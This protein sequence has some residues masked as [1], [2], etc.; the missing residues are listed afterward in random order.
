ML[1]LPSVGG[2]AHDARVGVWTTLLHFDHVVDDRIDHHSS[3]GNS[4]RD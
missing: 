2:Q 1:A 3:S 4:P